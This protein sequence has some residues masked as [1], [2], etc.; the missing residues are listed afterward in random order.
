MGRQGQS[1]NWRAQTEYQR[2]G[3]RYRDRSGCNPPRPVSAQKPRKVQTFWEPEFPA[4]RVSLADQ[5]T[6]PGAN[7]LNAQ[8]VQFLCLHFDTRFGHNTQIHWIGPGLWQISLSPFWRPV[9][10][11]ELEGRQGFDP[12][13]DGQ[14]AQPDFQGQPDPLL[15]EDFSCNCR[16][17]AGMTS[18]QRSEAP[19]M[20][21]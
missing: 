20:E 7:S 5:V 2:R 6:E 13:G 12:L 10:K 19:A 3:I 16:T 18:E 14:D 9:P 21:R 1:H 8:A 15:G 4:V 17:R 11:R